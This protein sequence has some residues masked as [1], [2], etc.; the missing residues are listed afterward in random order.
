WLRFACRVTRSASLPP[1]LPPG[2]L[3]SIVA[4]RFIYFC[5]VSH[6]VQN[7]FGVSPEPRKWPKQSAKAK[8]EQAAALA[9]LRLRVLF[10]LR[11]L[12]RQDMHHP[13]DGDANYRPNDHH[14]PRDTIGN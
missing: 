7:R 1:P 6:L 11:N 2:H 10:L 12:F 14:D 13:E 4:L 9:R 3:S 8:R 5:T